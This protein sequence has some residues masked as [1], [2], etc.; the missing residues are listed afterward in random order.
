MFRFDRYKTMELPFHRLQYC[1]CVSEEVDF[2]VDA[3]V[4]CAIHE[5]K[6]DRHNSSNATTITVMF[7]DRKEKKSGWLMMGG[8]RT[9]DESRRCWEKWQI[10]VRLAEEKSEN[11]VGKMVMDSL[12]YIAGVN[13]TAPE[14]SSNVDPFPFK[15]VTSGGSN[16]HHQQA[17]ESLTSLF[18]KMLTESSIPPLL[19]LLSLYC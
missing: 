7:F 19:G 8:G 15:I 2:K 18:K 9:D 10:S 11:E 16:G 6:D 5:L 12:L 1:K 3:A 4:T 17:A 13:W 14:S